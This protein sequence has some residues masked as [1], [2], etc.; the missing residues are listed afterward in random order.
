MLE[1]VE[2]ARRAG[3]PHDTVLAGPVKWDQLCREL[4]PVLGYGPVVTQVCVLELYV[5]GVR[6]VRHNLPGLAVGCP[7][8]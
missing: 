5:A 6:V 7:S 3:L 8:P 4:Q 2:V 1:L